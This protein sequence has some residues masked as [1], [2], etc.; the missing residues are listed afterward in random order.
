MIWIIS[1]T[2]DGREL[3]AELADRENLKNPD[4]R[5]GILMTV[6]SQYGKVLAEHTGIDIEV[7]RFTKPDMVRIIHDK[8]IELIIDASHPYAAI[9]SETAFSACRETGI[10]YIRYERPEIP[11]PDYDKLYVRRPN[12]Q[13]VWETASSLRRDPRHSA[14]LSIPKPSKAKKYGREYFP[15]PV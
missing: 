13:D 7:G 8:D 10:Q 6:V 4:E 1:G 14:H 3:G 5:K 12:W 15:L 11:L 2:Q 9:V